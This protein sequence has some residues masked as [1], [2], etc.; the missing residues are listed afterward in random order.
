M[1]LVIDE[2]IVEEDRPEHIAKH[3]VEVTEVLEVLTGN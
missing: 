1:D 2:L 3:G